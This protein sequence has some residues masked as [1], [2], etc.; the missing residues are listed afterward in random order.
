MC[1]K[2]HRRP[3]PSSGRALERTQAPAAVFCCV[4]HGKPSAIFM[5]VVL[6]IVWVAAVLATGGC[7]DVR[8]TAST[9]STWSSPRARALSCPLVPVRTSATCPTSRGADLRTS[10]RRRRAVHSATTCSSAGWSQ[11]TFVRASWLTAG[12]WTV[13]SRCLLSLPVH[14]F[15]RVT[16][17]VRCRGVLHCGR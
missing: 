5:C 9:T 6:A 8:T 10:F 1:G 14:F 4:H 17:L 2:A 13:P 16:M 15:C 7:G 11:T 12:P 3:P